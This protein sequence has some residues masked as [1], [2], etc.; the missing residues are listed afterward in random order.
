[1]AARVSAV[2]RSTIS[3]PAVPPV[4]HYVVLITRG[5]LTHLPLAVL[6][7]PRRQRLHPDLLGVPRPRRGA[8]DNHVVIAW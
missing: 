1:M 2:Q 5:R 8:Y 4:P 6:P 3:A 7:L